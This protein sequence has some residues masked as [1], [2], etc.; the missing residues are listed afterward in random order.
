MGEIVSATSL[1]QE[2]AGFLKL[3]FFDFN[4]GQQW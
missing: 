2:N 1:A 3:F 4:L